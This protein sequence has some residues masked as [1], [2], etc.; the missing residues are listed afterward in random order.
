[1][2]PL[3]AVMLLCAGLV[4]ASIAAGEVIEPGLY[5][6]HNHPDSDDLFAHGLRLDELF[7]V[8][9]GTDRFTFDFDAPGAAMFLSF[10]GTG[11]TISGTAFGGLEIGG[12]NYDPAFSSMIEIELTYADVTFASGDDDL[13]VHSNDITNLGSVTWTETGLT[14][15]LADFRGNDLFAFRFGDEHGNSG[16]RGFAGISGWG[17]LAHGVDGMRTTGSEWIFSAQRV[18][19]PT[20][21]SLLAAGLV[22]AR[23]RRR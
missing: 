14:I 18:P 7:D 20:T 22:F 17:G 9:P 16:H 1:M 15:P 2:K 6:L 12:G 19:G 3:T 13:V 23:R 4:P 21:L 11:L 8:T 5:R 10:N